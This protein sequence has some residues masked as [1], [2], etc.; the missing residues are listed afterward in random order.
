MRLNLEVLKSEVIYSLFYC[1]NSLYF[2]ALETFSH[3]L[4]ETPALLGKTLITIAKGSSLMKSNLEVSRF[5]P[6]LSIFLLIC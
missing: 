1:R 5:C 3:K 2:N 6:N 4:G